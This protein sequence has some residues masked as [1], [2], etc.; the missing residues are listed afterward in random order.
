MCLERS[1]GHEHADVGTSPC[2]EIDFTSA[3]YEGYNSIVYEIDVYL[4]NTIEPQ[5]C[6]AVLTAKIDDISACSEH[7]RSSGQVS[8]R[9]SD[10][11]VHPPQTVV[12][13]PG[14]VYLTAQLLQKTLRA[15]VRAFTGCPILHDDCSGHARKSLLS[16]LPPAGRPAGRAAGRQTC[17]PQ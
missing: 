7:S 5:V 9:T 1:R 15:N 4:L 3:G 17:I 6:R 12:L 14:H 11:C 8:W 10:H 13:S 2:T 16:L